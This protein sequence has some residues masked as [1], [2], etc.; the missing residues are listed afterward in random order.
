M[1]EV[2]DLN[3]VPAVARRLQLDTMAPP[4]VSERRRF[5]RILFQRKLVMFGVGVLVSW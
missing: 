3:E 2:V 4:H 5:F 1:S